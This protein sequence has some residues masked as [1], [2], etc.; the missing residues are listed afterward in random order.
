VAKT[1]TPAT[2]DE[3]L[4]RV[5]IYGVVTDVTVGVNL[6]FVFT[7]AFS[8]QPSAFEMSGCNCSNSRVKA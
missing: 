7:S 3:F 6:V 2:A 5:V 8:L 4:P 1:E